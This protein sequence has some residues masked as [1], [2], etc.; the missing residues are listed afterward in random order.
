MK[1][2]LLEHQGIVKLGYL[3]VLKESLKYSMPQVIPI[4][5]G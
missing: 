3:V 5:I 1:G 4:E 2:R